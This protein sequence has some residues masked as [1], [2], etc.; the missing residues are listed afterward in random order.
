MIKFKNRLVKF[1]LKHFKCIN[2]Q[3]IVIHAALEINCKVCDNTFRIH[4]CF[5]DH[6]IMNHKHHQNY[7]CKFCD[8]TFQV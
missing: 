7:V 2:E 5:N 6:I 4:T 3:R 1:V 8:E